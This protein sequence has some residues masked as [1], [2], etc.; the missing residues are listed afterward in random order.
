MP[1]EIISKGDAKFT[2]EIWKSLFTSCRT[3][4]L[5]S[6]TY[7]PQTNGQIERV[8]LILEDMLRLHVMH[9]PRKREGYLAF[10]E[11]DYNNGYQESLKMTPF[12]ALYG[13]K[14]NTPISWD[15]L[16]HRVTLG[17]EMLME[18]EQQ[19]T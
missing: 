19:M 10:V 13:K 4:L 11:F 18:L 8:S 12:K 1:K 15:N 3:Q 17:P 9:Q 7:H 5:F 14:C 2:L 16:V 6:T